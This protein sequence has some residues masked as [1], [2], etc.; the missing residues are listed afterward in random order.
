M[1]EAPSIGRILGGMTPFKVQ[2]NFYIPLFEVKI[3]ERY[4]NKWLD[5]LEGYFFIHNIFNSE[6]IN[7][8]LLMS[9]PHVKHWLDSYY[10]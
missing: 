3:D 4:L 10:L 7:F 9:L 8:T 2:V 1:T 6:R 5:Y